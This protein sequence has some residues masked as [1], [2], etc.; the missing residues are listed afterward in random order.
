MIS[1]FRDSNAPGT[2]TATADL[3][4]METVTNNPDWPATSPYKVERHVC[5]QAELLISAA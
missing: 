3:S 2:F 4:C 1:D 5:T